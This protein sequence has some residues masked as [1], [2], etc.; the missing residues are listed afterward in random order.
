MLLG[1]LAKAYYPYEVKVGKTKANL[2]E[3]MIKDQLKYSQKHSKFA[4]HLN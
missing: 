2:T 1:C 4:V 3:F